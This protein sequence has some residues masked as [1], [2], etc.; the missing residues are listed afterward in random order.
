MSD[1]DRVYFTCTCAAGKACGSTW[2]RREWAFAI[3]VL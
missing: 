2:L 3:R 1:D